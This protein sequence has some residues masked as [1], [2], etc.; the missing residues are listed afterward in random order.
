MEPVQHTKPNRMAQA[1]LILGIL[2]V[3]SVMNIYYALF[4]GSM[5]ILFAT[6]SR[7][8]SLKMSEKAIGG[9]AA[10]SAAIVLSIVLT[11]GSMLIL[12][13]LFGLET[14]MDPEAL[15][16][17]VTELYNK[18]LNEMQTGGSAL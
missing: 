15:Q 17:A 2:A 18:L 4:L 1:S 10:S 11:V 12:I 8:S 13:K 16:N 5:G 6:L 7:G 14:A 9:M 3:L